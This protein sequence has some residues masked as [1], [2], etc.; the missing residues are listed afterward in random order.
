MINSATNYLYCINSDTL[1]QRLIAK[2]QANKLE[3]LDEDLKRTMKESGIAVPP[4]SA[5]AFEG[6]KVVYLDDP[7]PDL[8]KRAFQKIYYPMFMS[9]KT[10]VWRDTSEK[11]TLP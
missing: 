2:S 1:E 5:E 3:I 10:F 4:S 11:E 8:F 6:R 7:D 9:K